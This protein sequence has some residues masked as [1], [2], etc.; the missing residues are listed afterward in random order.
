MRN[1]NRDLFNKYYKNLS[2]NL[3]IL[4]MKLGLSQREL[5]DE[6]GI[7][8]GT[9]W[10]IEKNKYGDVHPTLDTV[11]LIC[12]FFDKTIEEMFEKPKKKHYKKALEKSEK[13][14][15]EPTA[16]KVSDRN[17]YEVVAK[18]SNNGKDYYMF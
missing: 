5:A 6:I 11:F 15:K 8:Q 14:D 7:T 13:V 18:K 1:L 3:F 2:K 4:R 12:E 10:N 9:I 17:S 16:S